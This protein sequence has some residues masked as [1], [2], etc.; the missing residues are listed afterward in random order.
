MTTVR[1]PCSIPQS[2]WMSGRQQ[3]LGPPDRVILGERPKLVGFLGEDFRHQLLEASVELE[4]AATGLG[5]D[6]TPLLDEITQV[7]PGDRRKLRSVVAV[8]EDDGGLKQ[9][10]NRG[11][12]GV[13][14]LPGQRL[15][16]SR[17]TM[18]TMLRMSSG[19]LFQS[20]V[21][22]WRSLLIRTGARP[23]ARKSSAK[24]VASTWLRLDRAPLARNPRAC[25]ARGRAPRPPS[26]TSRAGRRTGRRSAGR[27][28]PGH[29]GK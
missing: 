12:V 27:R 23:L 15:F 10:W 13:D 16:Q 7:L 21:G 5:E 3:V 28:A 26:D 19:S 22:A 14:D 20:P 8:E 4:A 6:E 9:V 17:E 29:K 25:F 2:G 24:L 1:Q 11:D 18:F